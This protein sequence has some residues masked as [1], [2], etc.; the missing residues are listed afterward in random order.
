[1]HYLNPCHSFL[2]K[3]IYFVD[4]D[5]ICQFSTNALGGAKMSKLLG[6]KMA[7]DILIQIKGVTEEIQRQKLPSTSLTLFSQMYHSIIWG[8]IKNPVLITVELNILPKGKGLFCFLTMIFLRCQHK[9]LGAQDKPSQNT[10]IQDCRSRARNELDLISSSQNEAKFLVVWSIPYSISILAITINFWKTNRFMI[11]PDCRF[12]LPRN[13][14][15]CNKIDTTH[16]VLFSLVRPLL[17]LVRN[18]IM[19]QFIR[20]SVDWETSFGLEE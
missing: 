18:E 11:I 16:Q 17:P 9:E 15:S 19:N 13:C 14:S 1:M 20:S 5:Q 6:A 7:A 4:E 8:L 2:L 10:C 12:S 3:P